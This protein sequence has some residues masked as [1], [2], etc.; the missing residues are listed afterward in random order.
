MW[1]P[2]SS[3]RLNKSLMDPQHEALLIS[4]QDKKLL[5]PLVTPGDRWSRVLI[6]ML[7]RRRRD[8]WM[9]FFPFSS[10]LLVA[11]ALCLIHRV[12]FDKARC[13]NGRLYNAARFMI[14]LFSKSTGWAFR[15]REEGGMEGEKIEKRREGKKKPQREGENRFGDGER[16]TGNVFSL[17]AEQLPCSTFQRCAEG[18]DGGVRRCECYMPTCFPSRETVSQSTDVFLSYFLRLVILQPSCQENMLWHFR[19]L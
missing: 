14:C 11:S 13:W 10:L 3:C 4:S 18:E 2:V 1:T 8:P 19:F 12:D 5:V 16:A 17:V 7:R 9:L 6:S 15:E